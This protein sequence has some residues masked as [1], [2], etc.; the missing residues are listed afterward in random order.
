M[1][2]FSNG[3]K[4]CSCD[5]NKIKFREPKVFINKKG[6]I[7]EKENPVNM[8]IP[9]EYIWTLFKFNGEKEVHEMGRYM[10]PIDDLGNGLNS[11]WIVL[12]LNCEDCFDF[13][14]EPKQGDNLKI[15]QNFVLGPYISFVYKGDEWIIDH[16][17]PFNTKI[18]KIKNGKITSDNNT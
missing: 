17:D 14:Y 5:K 2:D 4:F 11:E 16:H 3:I 13:D 18:S 10:M 6:K 7:V 12:N 15:H 8:G 9:L 1:C